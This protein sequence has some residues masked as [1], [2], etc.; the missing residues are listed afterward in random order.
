MNIIRSI[1][2]AIGLHSER[3]TWTTEPRNAVE[4]YR[5]VIEHYLCRRERCSRLRARAIV[6]DGLKVVAA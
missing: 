3:M 6:M 5:L 4:G 2:C 1:L